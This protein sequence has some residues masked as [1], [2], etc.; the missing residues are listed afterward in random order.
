LALLNAEASYQ[1]LLTE[2]GIPPEQSEAVL[3][4]LLYSHRLASGLIAIAFV[5]GTTLHRRLRERALE[6]RDALAN[7]RAAVVD[8]SDPAPVP[9]PA[10]VNEA[11]ERVEVMFEQLA[12]MRT[13]SLRFKV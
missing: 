10:N 5:R 3:T 6:L 4:L 7:I 1:R 8:R 9:E 11:S 12:V 2:T 13:A